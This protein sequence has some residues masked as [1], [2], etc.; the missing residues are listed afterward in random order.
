MLRSECHHRC[1]VTSDWGECSDLCVVNFCVCSMLK[2][3]LKFIVFVSCLI[4]AGR[5]GI[6][7]KD[8]L[9]LKSGGLPGLQLQD[10]VGCGGCV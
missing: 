9:Y 4:G 2:G 3:G 10:D 8:W 5:C 6:K 7:D 1:N